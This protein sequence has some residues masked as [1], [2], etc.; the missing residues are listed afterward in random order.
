MDDSEG[1]DWILKSM[2]VV[3]TIVF[4]VAVWL[5]WAGTTDLPPEPKLI[6]DTGNHEI[7]QETIS[8]ESYWSLSFEVESIHGAKG[9][10]IRWDQVNIT[11]R[12][13][14]GARLA[15]D[16]PLNEHDAGAYGPG[17]DSLIDIQCWYCDEGTKDGI[18]MVGD[19]IVVTGVPMDVPGAVFEMWFKGR[20]CWQTSVDFTDQ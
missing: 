11:I 10:T 12:H 17:N 20:R 5:I 16:L 15:F 8:N 1:Q 18:L 9:E 13:A 3:F 14:N 4:I 6:I 7:T 2:M 19:L